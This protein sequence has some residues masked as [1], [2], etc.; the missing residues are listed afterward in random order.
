MTDSTPMQLVGI[1]DAPSFDEN[2]PDAVPAAFL[3]GELVAVLEQ[4]R[5]DEE[6]VENN[7]DV[8]PAAQENAAMVPIPS[9]LSVLAR[10]FLDLKCGGMSLQGM[11]EPR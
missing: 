2:I 5:P 3:D 7:F 9:A 6:F 8:I 10:Q 1:P 4:E 11:S